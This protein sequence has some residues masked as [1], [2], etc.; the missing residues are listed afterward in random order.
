MRRSIVGLFCVFALACGDP[1]AAAVPGAVTV[2]ADAVLAHVRAA[3]GSV[4]HAYREVVDATESGSVTRIVTVR[5]GDDVRE[6]FDQGPLHAERGTVGGQAWSQNDNGETVL[7]RLPEDTGTDAAAPASSVAR[8]ATPVDGYVLSSV[9]AS[10]YA[11]RRYVDRT[12]WRVLRSEEERAS[13]MRVTMYDYFRTVDGY[14]LPFHAVESDGHPE[15]DVDR[16]VVAF[17]AATVA[18]ADVAIPPSRTSFVA[19]P[20]GKAIV[21]LPVHEERDVFVVRV[22][23]GSRGLDFEIDSGASGIVLE[24][25]VARQLRLPELAATSNAFNAGRYR[26]TTTVVPEMKVGDLDMHDV[27]IR[28]VPSLE[29]QSELGDYKIVGL[30]GY[31]FLAALALKL[32]Y[33]NGTATAYA[34]G[35]FTPPVDFNGFPLDLDLSDGAAFTSIDI[36]GSTG[37]RF[38]IDTGAY[39]S[40]LLFDRFQRQHPAALIDEGGGAYRDIRMVGVGG[41]IPVKPYQLKAV[42]FGTVT[43]H[44]FVAY[45]LTNRAAYDDG[46][47]GVVGQKFLH[48]FDVYL[49]YAKSKAYFVFH[50]G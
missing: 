40:L 9:D 49:D 25:G 3:S 7:E 22:N 47:D 38:A 13:G 14:T 1:A 4:P 32:D 18:P 21:Q 35:A 24:S 48:L 37:D 44:D 41:D 36:N 19:F 50:D 39:G 16:R 15:D 6:T 31:D 20:P 2:T 43:F 8:V 34:P 46:T 17:G 42:R 5:A 23:V 28:T 29:G 45:A 10:G 30:L 11:T 33:F 12:T 27:V 26:E